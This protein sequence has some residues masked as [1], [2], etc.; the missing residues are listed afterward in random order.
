M[1]DAL[2]TVN[3]EWESN[4][5]QCPQYRFES[6]P[7]Y[8]VSSDTYHIICSATRMDVVIKKIDCGI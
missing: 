4:S 2:R 3:G 8:N 1:V 7:D 5:R 6:C